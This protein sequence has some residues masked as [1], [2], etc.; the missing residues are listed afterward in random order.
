[1]TNRVRDLEREVRALKADQEDWHKGVAYIA[2]SAGM[3]TLAC[4]WIA[5]RVLETRAELEEMRGLLWE[6]LE[7]RECLERQLESAKVNLQ[8]MTLD[9]NDCLRGWVESRKAARGET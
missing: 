5:N 2:A 7:T 1:M 8:V 9:R 6:A 3:D 4:T